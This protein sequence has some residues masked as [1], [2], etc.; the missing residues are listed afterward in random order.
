MNFEPSP[1]RL[2][3]LEIKNFRCFSDLE[4][5]FHE[6]LTV[7]VAPNGGGK[8]ALLD[9]DCVGW[10]QFIKGMENDYVTKGI[11]GSDVRLALSPEGQMQSIKPVVIRG[12]THVGNNPVGWSV[13]KGLS[14]A[15]NASAKDALGLWI[16]AYNLRKAVQDYAE[17]KTT[18]PTTLPVLGFYGTGRL[19]SG[20][21]V[22]EARR[23]KIKADTSAT[24][25]YDDCL[26]ASSHFEL[27][28]VW[29]ERFSR[30]AQQER[31]T[32]DISPHR[33]ADRIKVVAGA[34]DQLLK[35]TG[36]HSLSFDFGA[37]TI[38]A[39]HPVH[40][41]LPVSMLSDGLRIM[42]GLVGDIAH[43]CTRLNH[44]LGADAAR[45]TPGIIMIDEVDMHLHPE[46]QQM[47]LTALMD[48]FPLI[49]FIVTTHSPQVLT[50][51]KREC[52]RILE[53]NDKGSWFAPLPSEEIKGLESSIA[54]ND[55]M[56]VNPIP[57]VPEAQW[58]K[59]YIALIETGRHGFEEG[60]ALRSKLVDLYGEQH[61]TIVDCD[62]L[63]RFQSFKRSKQPP[64]GQ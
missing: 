16:A 45:L 34:V 8:T 7:F 49:Q 2:D 63:I 15:Q 36:W 14:S 52:I 33:P 46:W 37:E 60:S 55:V 57:D 62:R 51:V 28:E 18:Q 19:W 47:V 61:P 4:V 10:H 35:P 38:I 11:T 9:A 5:S 3:K 54:L 53:Q 27:F 43:R 64:A 22:T 56:D 29:F 39:R 1:T 23:K 42:I 6:K 44:H 30:S 12:S 48:A 31:E 13:D 58:L 26:S 21:K 17:R 41:A 25:G 24:S 40:G 20:K 32:G 59:D 50:T